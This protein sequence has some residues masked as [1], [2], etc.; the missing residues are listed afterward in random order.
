MLLRCCKNIAAMPERV[1]PFCAKPLEIPEELSSIITFY[2][3][4][5]ANT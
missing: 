2:T 1:I 3:T 5:L 4:V